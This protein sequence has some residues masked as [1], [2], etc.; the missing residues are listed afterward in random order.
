MPPSINCERG[1]LTRNSC[2]KY[3]RWHCAHWPLLP[4]SPRACLSLMGY[5]EEVGG[6]RE[7]R[8]IS[9]DRTGIV[10]NVFLRVHICSPGSCSRSILY[11]E[12]LVQSCT[13]LDFGFK[14]CV[15]DKGMAKLRSY[16][17]VFRR[18][19]IGRG[20][21]LSYYGCHQARALESTDFFPHSPNLRPAPPGSTPCC[22]PA[23]LSLSSFPT[24][25]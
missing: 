21:S 5:K 19:R 8:E 20:P 4:L 24:M 23:L 12:E 15:Y 2:F 11:L 10:S 9:V 6:C 25:W 17:W 3:S 13:D 1:H 16:D 7:R 22:S 14:V 18:D